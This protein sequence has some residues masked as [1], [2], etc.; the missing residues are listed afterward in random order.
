MIFVKQVSDFIKFVRLNRSQNSSS[1]SYPKLLLF[2]YML[3]LPIIKR[4]SYLSVVLLRDIA[5]SSK[6]VERLLDSGGL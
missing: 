5:S 2:M 1:L 3:K 6:N 4:F